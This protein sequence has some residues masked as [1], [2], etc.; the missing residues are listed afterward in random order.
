MKKRYVFVNLIAILLPLFSFSQNTL[1]IHNPQIPIWWGGI[2]DSGEIEEASI[3]MRPQG[4][5]A[6][7]EL[8]MTIGPAYYNTFW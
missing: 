3:T 1:A 7:V 6:E 2:S 8:E 5:Y 4:L